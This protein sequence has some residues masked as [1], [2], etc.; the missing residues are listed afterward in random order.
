MKLLQYKKDLE[1]LLD[2]SNTVS[3]SLEQAFLESSR[4]LETIVESS[5]LMSRDSKAII[6]IVTMAEGESGEFNSI[7]DSLHH[8]L[9]QTASLA[10][11]IRSVEQSVFDTSR[12]ISDFIAWEKHLM[13]TL[14]PLKTMRTFFLIET[15]K[16][17]ASSQRA[18]RSVVE[19]IQQLYQQAN[20]VT[21]RELAAMTTLESNIAKNRV[22]IENDLD[23]LAQSISVENQHL[24]ASVRAIRD[25][26]RHNRN[27][28]VQLCR[29]TESIARDVSDVV[30]AIQNEDIT[31][32]KFEHVWTAVRTILQKIEAWNASGFALDLPELPVFIVSASRIQ[33][34][35]IESVSH[36]YATSK[37]TLDRICPRMVEAV[38]VLD[39]EC[40]SLKEFN[41]LSTSA[42]GAIQLLLE[43]IETEGT[44]LENI[45]KV[46]SQTEALLSPLGQVSSDMSD[47][48]DN[49]TTD[50]RV[51]T[52]NANIMASRQG[53]NCG[54]NPLTENV[55]QISVAA[56]HL[57][58]NLRGKLHHFIQEIRTAL[59]TLHDTH[60]MAKSL[61]L[62]YESFRSESAN[63]LHAFRDKALALILN[64]SQNADKIESIFSSSLQPAD[65]S[66]HEACCRETCEVL[67]AVIQ[68][69][70][71]H[72]G[73]AIDFS[74]LHTEE[75]AEL[76][77]NYTMDS[78]R[79]NQA[80]VTGVPVT[81]GNAEEDDGFILF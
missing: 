10:T 61:R 50:L 53:R 17:D 15:A 8:F 36:D 19:D 31:G 51:V 25:D 46:L 14:E 30:T 70:L 16:L 75:I 20:Q 42:D 4:F 47:E 38:H 63:R 26:L 29:T 34:K 23:A 59:A 33:L 21:Q 80:A 2:R 9:D 55:G 81:A 37:A 60:Q 73:N 69:T 1:T 40:L 27:V 62:E 44:L 65:L 72:C 64:L 32:Q 71:S 24:L 39:N 49:I 54:L 52:I 28:D 35:Q 76:S 13:H 11:N 78:E 41:T 22:R 12:L 43:A 77:R 66:A 18:I 68:A 3:T 48:I 7:F 57:S 56:Q 5:A 74:Q 79:H 67:E 45:L 6:D 58:E